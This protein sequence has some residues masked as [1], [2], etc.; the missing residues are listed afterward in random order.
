MS[1]NFK[2]ALSGTKLYPITDLNLSG[3]SHADQV[4]QLAEGGAKIVQL[5]D[6]SSSPKEFYEGAEAAVRV[7]HSHGLKVIINDRVDIALALKADGVHLGQDDLPPEAARHL[8]GP[9]AII[10]FSTHTPAQA[11]Y[12]TELPV[13]Y[14]AVGPIFSTLTKGTA[15]PAVGVETLSLIQEIIGEIPLVAI[16]GITLENSKAVLAAGASAVAV[17]ADLWSSSRPA[18]EQVRRYS[19]PDI[20]TISQKE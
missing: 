20:H 2:E 3:L 18:V 13:D 14:I 12:A 16:G 17:I 6:K 15:E 4:L 19:G 9:E 8:L 1:S 7:A 11:R 10:G 5:R